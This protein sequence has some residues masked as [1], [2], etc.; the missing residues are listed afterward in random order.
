MFIYISSRCV[1]RQV[2]FIFRLTQWFLNSIHIMMPL[3]LGNKPLPLD[4][5]S[6]VC[7]CMCLRVWVCVWVC[8]CL[9]C[10]FE[11]VCE[12]VFVYVCVWVCL[13]GVFVYVFV[14]VCECGVCVWGTCA[15]VWV[16]VVC[17]YVSVCE[18]RHRFFIFEILICALNSTKLSFYPEPLDTPTVLCCALLCCC[19]CERRAK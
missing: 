1:Q 19:Y 17:V 5:L 4:L 7:M 10:V 8:E 16:C 15:C 12:C 14:C 3:S 11:C 13:F 6:C 2:L 9:V 18:H